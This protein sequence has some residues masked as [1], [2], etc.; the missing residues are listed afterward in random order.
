MKTYR[1]LRH[2]I[3]RAEGVH[4]RPRH[5]S[6]EGTARTRTTRKILVPA[7]V[8]AGLGAAAASPGHGAAGHDQASTHH[9]TDPIHVTMVIKPWI[10]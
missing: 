10:Y 1:S 6:P 9:P 8:L 4:A 5:E 7:L 2:M 3:I